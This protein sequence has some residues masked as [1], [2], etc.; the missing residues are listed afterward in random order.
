MGV[1]TRTEDGVC[2]VEGL[3][4]SS[5]GALLHTGVIRGE[6]AQVGAEQK[7]GTSW[8]KKKSPG[9]WGNGLEL[10]GTFQ[11]GKDG[12]EKT[13]RRWQCEKKG[14]GNEARCSKAIERP[15]VKSL[16]GKRGSEDRQ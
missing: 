15:G 3:G 7:R 6:S 13:Y 5:Q 12:V 16:V 2:L 11:G 9:L 8:G 10:L 1:K 14:V 4:W